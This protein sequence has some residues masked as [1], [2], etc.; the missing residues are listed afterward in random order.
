MKLAAERDAVARE[1]HTSVGLGEA[2]G[3]SLGHGVGLLIHELPTLS[4]RSDDEQKLEPGMV[5]TVE[6]GA[7]LDGWGGV[8][9]EEL[10]VLT[11]GE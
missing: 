7:Y 10:A 5:V 4:A 3:H 1:Y 6:P 11:F 2:F 8:R 9:H